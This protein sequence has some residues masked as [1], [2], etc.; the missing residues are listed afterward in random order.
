MNVITK[1][2][3][4]TTTTAA[5]SGTSYLSMMASNVTSTNTNNNN[6]IKRRE[7]SIGEDS[8]SQKKIDQTCF[9][10]CIN[11]MRNNYIYLNTHDI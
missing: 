7:S 5:N 4:T 8:V 3:P 10:I 6:N 2:S 11:L 9:F 1:N